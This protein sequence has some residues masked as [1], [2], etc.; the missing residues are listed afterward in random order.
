MQKKC[1]KNVTFLRE[2]GQKVKIGGIFAGRSE[3]QGRKK[4][5]PKWESYEV[6]KNIGKICRKLTKKSISGFVKMCYNEVS[7]F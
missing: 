6:Q 1:N 5:P 2:W 3:N 4:Q 7:D